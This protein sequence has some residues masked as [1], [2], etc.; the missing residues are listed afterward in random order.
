ME[1]RQP[2][3]ERRHDLLP[4]VRY[5]AQRRIA[6][7]KADYWDYATLLEAAV[8]AGDE[9]GARRALGDALAV[10]RENWEAGTTA[11]NLGRIRQSREKR[12]AAPTWAGSIED[13]LRAAAT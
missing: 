1:I 6:S 5:A 11:D 8:L 7:G 13:E 12:S 10:M 4:V 2:P 9:D 3:D